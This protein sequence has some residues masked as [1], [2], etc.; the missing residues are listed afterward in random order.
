MSFMPLG[1]ARLFDLHQPR[2]ADAMRSDPEIFFRGA[3][4]AV[5]SARQ[6]FI[7][8]PKAFA[9]VEARG[10]HSHYLFAWKT[11]AYNWLREHKVEFW[12]IVCAETSPERAML[13]VTQCPGLNLTKGAFVLQM[14]GHDVACLDLWNLERAG[15]S[16]T[17]YK[18]DKGTPLF[19]RKLTQYVSD[20]YGR[21]RELWNAWCEDVGAFY[22]RPATRISEMHFEM[23]VP[24]ALRSKYPLRIAAEADTQSG[25]DCPF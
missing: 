10:E 14:L 11:E 13:A 3:L 24:K 23:V 21:S 5:L 12:R 17:H 20:T 8:L 1:G 25:D 9:D 19:R 4:L 6:Q 2:I 22:H 18:A 7:T 15:L 16:L